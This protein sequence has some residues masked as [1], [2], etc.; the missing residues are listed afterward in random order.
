MRSLL[1]FRV[2]TISL[3]RPDGRHR[4]VG[5][6]A[7]KECEDA[8]DAKDAKEG[9][10]EDQKKGDRTARSLLLFGVLHD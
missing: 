6:K 7:A 1:F 4:S 10:N 9:Y 2:L 5:A 8:K 3:K